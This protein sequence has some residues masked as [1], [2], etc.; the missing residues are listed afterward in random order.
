MP[1]I[2][3]YQL[4]PVPLLPDFGV[5]EVWPFFFTGIDFTSPLHM[6]DAIT[7]GSWLWLCLYTC[8]VTRATHLDIVPDMTAQ[9]F[10][11]SL[12]RFTSRRG[13][14]LKIV[15]DNA[16]T[17]KAASNAMAAIMEGPKVL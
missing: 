16:K 6:N 10:I 15:S 3:N 12:K 13:L 11:R 14:P 7:N 4:P 9:A 5:K 1:Q 2:F 8:C 17:F